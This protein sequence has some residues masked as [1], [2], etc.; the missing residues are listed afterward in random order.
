MAEY[1]MMHQYE[2]LYAPTNWETDGQRFVNRLTAILDDI[3]RRYGRLTQKDLGDELN[4]QL[5]DFD[6]KLTVM[7]GSSGSMQSTVAM[8]ESQLQA[9]TKRVDQLDGQNTFPEG[10]PL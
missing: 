8:L 1:A 3:Y 2:P 7:H 5:K 6:S 4:H 10:G 9:L